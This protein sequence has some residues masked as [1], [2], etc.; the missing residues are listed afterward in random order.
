MLGLPNPTPLDLRF[1]LFGVPVWVSAWHWLGAGYF[2]WQLAEAFGPGNLGGV[3][4]ATHLAMGMLCV[5]LSILL[6]EMGHA[7]AAHWFGMNRA[8]LMTMLGGLAYGPLRPGTKWWQLVLIALAGPFVQFLFAAILFG[9]MLA[10][11]VANG[12]PVGG[13]PLAVTLFQSLLLVNIVWPL[14]NL[15][16]IVPLD[17]GHVLQYTLGRFMGRRGDVWAGRLGLLLAIGFA[18]LFLVMRQ[19]YMTVLFGFLAVQNY[20]MMRS[21]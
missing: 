10:A 17:G 4:L 16:P 13:S 20:Q 12:G 2:G 14:F 11:S 15:L 5:F 7:M 18:A 1:S 6:H 19:T 21:S 3:T 9:G 8:I